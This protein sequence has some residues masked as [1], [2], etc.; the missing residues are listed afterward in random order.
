VET[1]QSIPRPSS[2]SQKSMIAKT[3]CY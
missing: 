2:I 1:G 3:T